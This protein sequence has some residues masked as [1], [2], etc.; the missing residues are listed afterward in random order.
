LVFFLVGRNDANLYGEGSSNE[1]TEEGK[2]EFPNGLAPES[3]FDN[4]VLNPKSLK[5][6]LKH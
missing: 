5:L 1:A 3:L 2:E 6:S 4:K